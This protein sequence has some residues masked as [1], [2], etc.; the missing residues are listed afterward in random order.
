MF[1]ALYITVI[2]LIYS[3]YLSKKAVWLQEARQYIVD[4]VYTFAENVAEKSA[5]ELSKE[6]ESFSNTYKNYKEEIINSL[7]IQ[8]LEKL[9]VRRINTVLLNPF[10]NN[11]ESNVKNK[12]LLQAIVSGEYQQDLDRRKQK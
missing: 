6:Y 2:I 5:D 9:E 7:F 1:I 8:T 12:A 10:M 4:E 11:F 3:Y